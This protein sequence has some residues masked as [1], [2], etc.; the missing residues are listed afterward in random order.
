MKATRKWNPDKLNMI[1]AMLVFGTIGIF[2]RYLP[3]SSAFLAFSRGILGGVFLLVYMLLTK[4]LP[5]EKIPGKVFLRLV[6]IGVLIGFNW[7]ML[8]E[9][10][11]YTSVAVATLC[12]YMQPIILIL[13]S[14]LLF[15]ERL[16]MKKGLCAAISIFGMVLVSGVLGGSGAG[17]PRGVLLGLGAAFLYAI[18]VILSK[19]TGGVDAYSR[20]TVQLL[21]AGLV[22][23]PYLLITGDQ[24]QAPFQVSTLVL[25]LVVG[26]VHTGI[27]YAMYFGSMQKLATQTV[28]LLGYIDPVSAVLLSALFLREPLGLLGGIGAVMIIG[29]A[30][31]SEA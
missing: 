21:S 19:K 14:P 2:R 30:I 13:A 22:M 5:K 20:T 31:W 23:V 24:N 27:A 10:Y 7:I 28:A 6:G 29:A 3:V 4:R 15:G 11:N 12:Y 17:D 1:A 8:F 26:I 25:L 18:V 9:A 16:T